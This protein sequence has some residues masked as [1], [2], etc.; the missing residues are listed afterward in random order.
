MRVSGFSVY[1]NLTCHA[2]KE[3]H[4]TIFSND[5]RKKQKKQLTWTLKCNFTVHKSQLQ[6]WN[7]ARNPKSVC[8]SLL[9]DYT[10]TFSVCICRRSY[11]IQRDTELCIRMNKVDG[12]LSVTETSVQIVLLVFAPSQSSWN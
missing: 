7:H 1:A 11:G 12:M 10:K 2:A 8:F 3:T 9:A 5:E 4:D 6:S